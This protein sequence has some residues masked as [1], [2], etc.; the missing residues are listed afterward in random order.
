VMDLCRIS[1]PQAYHLLNRLKK[2]DKIQQKGEKRY[3]FYTRG[4]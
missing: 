2:Q 3:A 1:G 4:G